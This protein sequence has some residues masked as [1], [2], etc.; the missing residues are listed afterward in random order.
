LAV[1][2]TEAVLLVV[3]YYCIPQMRRPF[4]YLMVLLAVFCVLTMIVLR[5]PFW[6][7]LLMIVASVAFSLF[8]LEMGQK[9]LNIL[10]VKD[11][12]ERFNRPDPESAYYFREN[13]PTSFLAAKNRL[14]ADGLD[15]GAF[16]DRFHADSEIVKKFSLF[17]KWDYSNGYT[18]HEGVLPYTRQGPPLGFEL[19]PDN[20]SRVVVKT[21]P[22][23][24]VVHDGLFTADRHG[25]RLTRANNDSEEVYIFT[26]CSFMFGDNL[27]DDQ[28]LPHYFSSEFGFELSVINLSVCAWGPHQVLR[29]LE[30]DYHL[31]DFNLSG[32]K[33]KRVY[34]DLIDNHTIRVEPPNHPL[35][36]YYT[37]ENGKLT[38]KG[39]Y[40]E[41]VGELSNI[42]IMM[43][44]SRI[45]PILSERIRHSLASNQLRHRWTV[46]VAIL[47]EMERIC[48]DRYDADFTVLYWDH[49]PAVLD[50]LD[51]NGIE[52][53]SV[54]DVF[55]DDW[56]EH[57]IKYYLFDS[58][59]SAYANRKLAKYLADKEKAVGID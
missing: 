1:V 32:K 2:A 36:P 38:F 22:G 12:R 25:L 29:D 10:D 48:R 4:E 21:N 27:N 53:I 56:R 3:F 47:K 49:D 16:E 44:R 20:V 15:D 13:D 7:G 39:P 24:V 18:L 46:T 26:G 51:K 19:T 28:T 42:S 43:N 5:K 52:V 17:H 31:K 50:M 11:A 33:V 45:Y 6:R 8:L 59:P 30:L 14:V 9:Y 54:L 35:A 55:D 37:I 41:Y 40:Q 57:M 58:H 34:Y 23:D